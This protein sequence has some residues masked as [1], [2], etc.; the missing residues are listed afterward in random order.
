MVGR[1]GEPPPPPIRAA[2]SLSKLKSA[3]NWSQSGD[4]SSSLM[5]QSF[6]GQVAWKS[7]A[8]SSEYPI[9][10]EPWSRLCHRTYKEGRGASRSNVKM[11]KTL[12]SFQSFIGNNTQ[13][14]RY[15]L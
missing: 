11:R 13:Y 7:Y 1:G 10:I 4:E 3:R 2:S 6:Q 9:D 12:L 5:R 15:V 14:T 8:M